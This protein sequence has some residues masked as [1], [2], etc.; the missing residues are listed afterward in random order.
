MVLAQQILL[1]PSARCKLTKSHTLLDILT[2]NTGKSINLA[3]KIVSSDK[4]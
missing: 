3:T 4:N 2:E 1:Y